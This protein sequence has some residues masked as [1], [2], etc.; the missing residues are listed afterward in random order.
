MEVIFV[1]AVIVFFS[2]NAYLLL[3]KSNKYNKMMLL[4]SIHSLASMK[5][6][7]AHHGAKAASVTM[8]NGKLEMNYFSI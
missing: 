3:N 7:R 8:N 5:H 4:P 1:K 6:V 2:C